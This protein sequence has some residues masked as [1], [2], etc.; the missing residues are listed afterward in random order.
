MIT[1]E[2]QSNIMKGKKSLVW[3]LDNLHLDLSP[4]LTAGW[5]WD[6]LRIPNLESGKIIAILYDSY[7]D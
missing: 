2:T 1:H 4:L 6:K 5:P 3:E 7:K